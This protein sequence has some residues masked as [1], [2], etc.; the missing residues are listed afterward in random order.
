ME[1][2]GIFVA[3]RF[4]PIFF[5]VPFVAFVVILLVAAGGC[6]KAFVVKS[7][8]LSSTAAPGDPVSN[9]PRD[10]NLTLISTQDR[11]TI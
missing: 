4:L 5:F 10:T 7:L 11:R 6:A 8:R 3:E 1:C 9:G 2:G